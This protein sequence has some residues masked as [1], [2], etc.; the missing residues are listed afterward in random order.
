M[1]RPD[2]DIVIHGPAPAGEELLICAAGDCHGQLDRMYD[3][4]AH[5]EA[6]VGRQVDLV[7]QVGDLGVWPD[8]DR[9]DR[10][11]RERGDI[12]DYARWA[13]EGRAVPRPT[14]FVPGNHED[15]S[16]LAASPPPALL[17]G[18]HLLPWGRVVRWVAGD[19]EFRIAGLGGC[20]SPRSYLM[21]E[22]PPS[23]RKHYRREEV[24]V[25]L[26][27]AP[28]SVDLLVTHD[29]PA[30]RF[31]DV[32][33]RGPGHRNFRSQALGIAELVVHLH[34]R[35]ALHGHFHGRY[36][37][38]IE[39]VRVAGMRIIGTPRGSSLA[40][41][42]SLWFFELPADGSPIRSVVE[43]GGPQDLSGVRRELGPSAL[44]KVALGP[45]AE[46]FV[47]CLEAWRG[48][49]LGDDPLPP[50][51]KRAIYEL[52]PPNPPMPRLLM[53]LLRGTELRP[54][55]QELLPLLG[56]GRQLEARLERLP[57]ASVARRALGLPDSRV[58]DEG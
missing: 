4:F 30:G 29:A 33:W 19:P 14:L 41:P 47:E 5:M 38:N 42:A 49:V 57:D 28:G 52:L 3:T 17:P 7:L 46:A 40:E 13:T 45:E 36:E 26:R 10:A 58:D 25:L 39:D 43:W 21:D 22:L 15:M 1:P 50:G 44:A 56:R 23:R 24:R 12:G 53:A 35:L 9:L 18:L 34:P 20:F 37:R 48:Q 55:V 2:T 54:L 6:T 27:E 11:T 51:W 8:P 16:V 32:R 31:Q